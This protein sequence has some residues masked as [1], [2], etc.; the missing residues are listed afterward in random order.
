MRDSEFELE[1]QT[2]SIGKKKRIHALE[3]SPSGERVATASGDLQVRIWDLA[4]GTVHGSR[5]PSGNIVRLRP[6]LSRTTDRLV[7]AGTEPA[8]VGPCREQL[9]H[10]RAGI[11]RGAGESRL[12]GLRPSRRS[13]SDALDRLG[14]RGQPDRA[15]TTEWQVQPAMPSL[16]NTTGGVAFS[17]D[18]RYL[19]T[20]HIERSAENT[21]YRRVRQL[22]ANDYDTSS[23]FAR[24]P[25]AGSCRPSTAGSRRSRTSPSRRT[26]LF[27]AARPARGCASGTSRVNREI[28]LHKRGT[29]HF[30]GLSFTH[31]GRFL[32]TVSNDETVRTSGIR[33]PGKEHTHSPGRSAACFNIV[34]APDGLRAAAGSDSGQ[35]VIWDVE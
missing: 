26:A 20:G 25:T 5:R 28:A 22:R 9:E 31:D 32:A 14:R 10:D 3:F 7:F 34:F 16:A 18:G 4:T 2:L 6:C 1:M 35:V 24:C 33:G 12:P 8:V 23:T 13:R 21:N 15:R 27:V 11:T 30:Q 17:R 19:A 29:K